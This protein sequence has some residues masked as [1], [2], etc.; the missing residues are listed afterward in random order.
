MRLEAGRGARATLLLALID[1][2]IETY[3]TLDSHDIM[4]RS[5]IFSDLAEFGKIVDEILFTT[6][7]EVPIVDNSTI[8][9]NLERSEISVG[10][11]DSLARH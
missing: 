7:G 8:Y 11:G 1:R 9:I 10:G 3:P 5:P 2:G 4:C 6:K